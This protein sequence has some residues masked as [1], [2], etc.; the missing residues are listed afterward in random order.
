MKGKYATKA[1][2]RAAATDNEVIAD[3]RERLEQLNRQNFALREQVAVL[4]AKLGRSVTRE[5]AKLAQQEVESLRSEVGEQR[6]LFREYL[7]GLAFEIFDLY[8]KHDCSVGDGGNADKFNEEYARLFHMSDRYGELIDYMSTL[9]NRDSQTA[10]N[11]RN[12][13]ATNTL[14]KVR[15]TRAWLVDQH[16]NPGAFRKAEPLDGLTKG[17]VSVYPE[18]L[19]MPR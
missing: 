4:N 13:R 17:R 1:I 11:R 19:G 14:K 9:P 5:A 3:M 16:R 10:I 18:D 12:R 7:Q 2:N 15:A 6:D 8:A